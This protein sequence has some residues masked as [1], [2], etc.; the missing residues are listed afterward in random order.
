MGRLQQRR[1]RSDQRPRPVDDPGIRGHGQYVGNM[2]GDDCAERKCRDADCY[3]HENCDSDT[4]EDSKANP[5]SQ[6]E[7]HAETE[8]HTDYNSDAHGF[9][10]RS[11]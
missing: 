11:R 1:R 7:A 6:A 8:A 4:D 2:V 5:H 10:E 3:G 9:L